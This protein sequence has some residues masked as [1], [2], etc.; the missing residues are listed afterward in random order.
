MIN[1]SKLTHTTNATMKELHSHILDCEDY[2]SVKN[3]SWY[4]VALGL[5]PFDDE[6]ETAVLTEIKN[7]RIIIDTDKFH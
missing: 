2:R 3:V 6:F 7:R 4:E 5:K 1:C